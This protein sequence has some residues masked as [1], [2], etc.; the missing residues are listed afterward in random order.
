MRKGIAWLL[1]LMLTLGLMGTAFAQD[2]T[3]GMVTITSFD[4]VEDTIGIQRGTELVV[5]SPTG[6]SGYF[7]T[8][9]WGTNTADMD[10]R[11]LLHGY[12]T[13]AWTRTLGLA[14]NGTAV[15]GVQTTEN[16]D[17]SR[18]Y[19][20]DLAQNMT[21]NNGTPITAADYVFSLLLV[22]APQIQE[23]GGTPQGLHHLVGFD[24]YANGQSNTI[25]G[26][27]LL[28]EYQFSLHISADFL[29]Y[30]YGLAMLNTTPYPISVIAP[31]C[32]IKD[33]GQGAYIGA[34]DTAAGMSGDG[35]TPGVFS[36]QMLEKTMLDPDTGYVFN[37]KVTSGP[38]TLTSY[39]KNANT[40][41]FVINENYL[42]NYEGQKP[43]IEKLTFKQ[44]SNE[45]MVADLQN[46]QAGL[47]NKVT[48]GTAVEQ[49][50]QLAMQ[51]TQAQ[52]ASY[53]RTG[54]AFLAFACEENP[55]DSTA[56]RNAVALCLDKDALVADG[57][58]GSAR[59]VYGYYGLGQWMAT[60]SDAGDAAVGTEALSVPEVLETLDRPMDI[61]AANALLEADGWTLNADGGA[62]VAGQDAVRHKDVDGTRVPLVIKWA[63]SAES[64]V[65]DKIQELLEATL[66]Q[67]GIGLE[68]TEMPF[69]E[70]L[71]HYYR[72]VDREY[73]MFYLA[74][75]FTYIFDPY[76]DFNTAEAYQGMTNTSG[77]QDESLMNLAKDMRETSPTDMR[78][79]A[80]KWLLFQEKFVELM[81]MVP[82][83]S[84][85]YFDF[86]QNDLQ[87]YDIAVHSGW[88]LAIPYAY[89]G[90]PQDVD[91]P[92]GEVPEGE[93]VVA[94]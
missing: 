33:D 57:V 67:A 43:H 26:I 94:F 38:Y 31:G 72:Q 63:K 30:F 28:G 83:Y 44:G 89:I 78:A 42:G 88:S 70:V 80:D 46:G 53:L 17:G 56:V 45:T 79:Y 47:L 50:Q 82:L 18:T 16:A 27:R 8:D 86:F 5:E 32:E 73:N 85:V 35:Y 81:P 55:T 39:D 71:S 41:E 12:A 36:A 90:E 20:I 21:Y 54:F 64:L 1:V 10:V 3:D 59:R 4:P 14:I 91:L 62:Y 69:T 52:L 84:N 19:V 49:G 40:A 13:V 74:S 6:M 34:A 68:V 75:N 22:S 15:T 61:A 37:P 66:P 77:L 87:G 29:P 65:A 51:D 2:S 24:A 93:D 60:Y 9:L 25:S 92:E 23:I 11:A 76:Y 58:T 48:N 7:A